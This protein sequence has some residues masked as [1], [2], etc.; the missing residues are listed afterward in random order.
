MHLSVHLVLHTRRLYC[1][2]M[3]T[4]C[5]CLSLCHPLSSHLPP[6][7]LPPPP[8]PM[9]LLHCLL[10]PLSSVLLTSHLPLSSSLRSHPPTS[11]PPSVSRSHS[12]RNPPSNQTGSHTVGSPTD[13]GSVRKPGGGKVQ[14]GIPEVSVSLLLWE[15]GG[16]GWGDGVGGGGGSAKRYMYLFSFDYQLLCI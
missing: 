3:V 5:C 2:H 11:L 16:G 6:F 12:D 8:S 7:S 13:A 14:Q 4:T 9:S 10:P 15:G 1:S